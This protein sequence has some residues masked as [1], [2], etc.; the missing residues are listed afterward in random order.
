MW[1]HL[2]CKYLEGEGG[3][4]GDEEK[5]EDSQEEDETQTDKLVQVHIHNY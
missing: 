3:E 1:P 4:G 2:S 5:K